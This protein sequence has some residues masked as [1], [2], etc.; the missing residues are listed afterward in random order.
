MMK[1]IVC[2]IKGH[3]FCNSVSPIIFKIIYDVH[4]VAL[5]QC[6]CKRCKAIK[7]M[8]GFLSRRT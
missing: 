8:Y 5:E 2:F 3:D 4:N 7:N 6:Y 1:R